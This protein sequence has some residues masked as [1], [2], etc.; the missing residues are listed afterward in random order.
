MLTKIREKATGILAWVIVIIISIP[1]AL[2]GVNSYFE[3]GGEAVVATVEG[4]D[5]DLNTFQGA[6]A[7]QRRVVTQ[8]MQ[9]NPGSDYFESPAFRRQVLEGLIQNT[10]ET[11]WA[12]RSGYRVSDETLG[13]WIRQLPYFQTD[14]RFD[15][16]RY[17]ALV[18]NAGMSVARFEQQ[19]RQELISD[20]IRSAFTE[21]AFV[22]D[23]EVDRA[24]VLLEQSR[25]ADYAVLSANDPSV[26][27]DVSEQD[28]T[29]WYESRRD[30]YFVPE[31]MRVNYLVLS[32]DDIAAGIEIS[33][34]EARRYYESN[35]GRFGR[36]EQRSVSHILLSLPADADDDAE[37]AARTRAAELAE[38]ARGGEDFAEL[39]RTHSDDSG[40]AASGGDLGVLTRGAMV[41]PFEDAANALAAVGD[42][43][44]PVRSRFGFHVIK[45]TALREADTA[46]F[47]SV[48]AEIEAELRQRQAE[49]Q[50]LEGVESFATLVY[51]QPENLQAA[52]DE[53]Q[54]DIQSSDWF[55][56]D[57]GDGIAADERF[58]NI[59][60]SEDVRV[61]DLN[62]DAFELDNQRTAAV[63]RLEVR[64]RRPKTLD[65]VREEI[66]QTLVANRRADAVRERGESLLQAINDGASFEQVVADNNLVAA[67]FS[68][69]RS[70]ALDAE[71]RALVPVLFELG[72]NPG[73]AVNG[74]F[75]TSSGDY[76]LYRLTEVVDGDPASVDE[77]RREAVRNLL[78]ARAA[79]GLYRDFQQALREDVEVE[80]HP[81]QL[82]EDPAG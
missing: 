32:V 56:R 41:K 37:A 81:G 24:L 30:D 78:R 72:W 4:V 38:R 61:D 40:S 75:S 53:L 33:E 22:A 14:G 58:R 10:A 5:I 70:D 76:L 80:I 7:E 60:F 57:A 26:S 65:E 45:L 19:Q 34:E 25:S 51:E 67:S 6:V 54:L 36:P 69:T 73:E 62:S 9:Q 46:P 23:A 15:A 68:G 55:S 48:R 43:S 47:D 52:A 50:Y 77:E 8:L 59:A 82:G 12:D 3:G 74:G 27:V 63:H 13:R 31:Q 17:Q 35:P 18:A 20:Q 28:I 42:V 79:E 71:S 44:D 11:A 1:F 16:E 64:E 21:S 2:W 66:R 49:G 39:A 29:E